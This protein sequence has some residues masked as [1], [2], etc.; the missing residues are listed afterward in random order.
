MLSVA[1]KSLTGSHKTSH[2]VGFHVP[3]SNLYIQAPVKN[4]P[5]PMGMFFWQSI[6]PTYRSETVLTLHVMV[7]TV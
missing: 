1:V 4:M 5:T 2:I 3:S 7:K 6:A